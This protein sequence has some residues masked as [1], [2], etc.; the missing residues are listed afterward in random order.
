MDEL[1]SFTFG[2]GLFFDRIDADYAYTPFED[3]F[4]GPWAYFKPHL[5]LVEACGVNLFN[6][7]C[8][9]N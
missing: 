6:Q 7:C 2:I 1:R 9:T 3:G 5:S 4:D 8:R